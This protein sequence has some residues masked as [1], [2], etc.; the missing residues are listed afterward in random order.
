MPLSPFFF[1]RSRLYSQHHNSMIDWRIQ[2][3]SQYFIKAL[4]PQV[5]K[6]L[7]QKERLIEF[8]TG[9][10]KFLANNIDKLNTLGPL[11]YV[12]FPQKNID[13][14]IQ[15]LGLT[16]KE[17]QDV[18]N[19]VRKNR[20]LNTDYTISTNPLYVSLT[21]AT[22]YFILQADEALKAHN[23]KLV[24]ACEDNLKR[25]SY[26]MAVSNYGLVMRRYFKKC[27]PNEAVMQYA[28]SSMIEKNRIRQTGSMLD[29]IYITTADCFEFYRERLKECT[30]DTVIRYINDVRTRLNSIMRNISN[31]YYKA[32]EEKHYL[33]SESESLEDE[34]FYQADS[35][36][37][38]INRL[39]NKVVQTLVT[40][41]PDMKLVEFAAKNNRM[42]VSD[43]RSYA[44]T[45][46]TQKQMEELEAIVE[47]LL[48]L[49]FS[50]DSTRS[51]TPRDIGTN[52]FLYVCLNV[53]K[54]PNTNN[55]QIIRIKEVLDKWVNDLNMYKKAGTV[56]TINNHRRAIY[57]L[58]VLSIIKSAK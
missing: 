33:Q 11:R 50:L 13:Q 41:G 15:C 1:M 5:E 58:I 44:V 20:K 23:K 32:F 48:V 43:L 56:G 55:K 37:Q 21:M 7:S 30:D 35:N 22:R 42:A 40:N 16:T 10:D 46:C 4:Y 34:K 18:G 8:Q 51:Y 25:C 3:M 19:V 28:I 27:E 29:T 38:F 39:T 53:Y 2:I 31:A 9:I 24:D 45:L 6:S 52:K 17:L 54:T 57:M 47:S 12:A 14:L 36:T 49:F 26:Y